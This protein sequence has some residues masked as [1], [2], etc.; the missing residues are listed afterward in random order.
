MFCKNDELQ[1]SA[2]QHNANMK[3]QT[4]TSSSSHVFHLITLLFHC[5]F[6]VNMDA[7]ECCA[8]ISC[9]VSCMKQH[10]KNAALKLKEVHSYILAC[11]SYSI[12]YFASLPTQ[13]RIMCDKSVSCE[14]LFM[15]ADMRFD[16][17]FLFTLIIDILSKCLILKYGNIAIENHDSSIEKNL[18]M[19]H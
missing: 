13:K 4:Y 18:I 9:S 14:R 19:A 15:C 10:S 11:F 5:V 1:L 8:R 17:S 2:C 7:F 3:Y 6:Y 12:A 16:R